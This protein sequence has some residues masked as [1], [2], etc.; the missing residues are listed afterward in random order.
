[1]SLRQ[2]MAYLKKQLPAAYVIIFPMC[3]LFLSQNQEKHVVICGHLRRQT[4]KRLQRIEDTNLVRLILR[5]ENRG[6]MVRRSGTHGTG[7][8]PFVGPYPTDVSPQ[9]EVV[10]RRGKKAADCI[11]LERGRMDY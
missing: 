5:G 3:A 9:T 11:I 1:M 7:E 10:C 4:A 6:L 8:Y 2:N